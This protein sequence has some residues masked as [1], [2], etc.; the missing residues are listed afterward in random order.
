MDALRV[1][2]VSVLTASV[3]VG[4][5]MGVPAA[6]AGTALCLNMPITIV[7]KA[8]AETVG[9]AGEDVILGTPGDDAIRAFGG[10]DRICTRGG[11]DSVRGGSGADR[12]NGGSGAD[13]LIGGRGADQLEGDFGS[14]EV[15][16]LPRTPILR[17]PWS[18]ERSPYAGS[19]VT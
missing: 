5:T 19:K 11:R 4:G 7:A 10:D 17:R 12:G 8:G 18:S 13:L 15:A 1:C 14:D 2:L 3:A 6:E 16:P 9:T